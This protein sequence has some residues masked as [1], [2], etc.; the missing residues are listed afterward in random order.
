SATPRPRS[1]SPSR[2]ARPTRRLCRSTVPWPSSDRPRLLPPRPA[3][4]VGPG[5]GGQRRT[6]PPRYLTL[7]DL[8]T[9]L[10]MP[11]NRLTVISGC[12][13]ELVEMGVI[14]EYVG[15]PSGFLYAGAPCV[16]STLWP[17]ADLSS[18]LLMARF[19]EEWDNGRRSVAAALHSAQRWLREIS[20]GR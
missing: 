11:H 16:L 3:A 2:R 17:V 13:S 9:R 14:D 6:L 15:L 10:H 5:A 12:E 20:S 4:P 1:V 18:A 8:F 7:A 19:H